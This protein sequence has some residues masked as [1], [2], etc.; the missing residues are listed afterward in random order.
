[1]FSNNSNERN[2]YNGNLSQEIA[3][4]SPD[5]I[6]V[7]LVSYFVKVRRRWKPALAV[8]LATMGATALLSTFL[9]KTYKAESK[10]LFKQKSAASLSGVGKDVGNLTPLLNTQSPL[11]TQIQVIT[12]DPVLQQTIDRLKLQDGKGQPLK[13]KDLDKKLKIDLVGGSDVLDIS[14]KHHDPKIAANVVNTLIDVYMNEQIRS[15]QSEPATAKEFINKQLPPLETKVSEAE[16]NLQKFRTENEI[17]DLKEEKRTIVNDLGILN[18]AISTTGSQ[19]QGLQAQTSALQSQ[20]G[21]N[22]NQAISA[23]QLSGEPEVQSIL[24]RID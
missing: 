2:S 9:Q 8:F 14:Y 19:L 4:S 5:S 23:N 22:L 18:R 10:L 12:S 16:S 7:N 20:L 24:S 3:P 21:L 6:D 13:P 15:N 11:S 17:V 1:M